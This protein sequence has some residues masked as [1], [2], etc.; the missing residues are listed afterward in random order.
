MQVKEFER[1]RRA[2]RARR[3]YELLSEAIA[4]LIIA[5]G[6]CQNGSAFLR[7]IELAEKK[8]GEAKECKV[9]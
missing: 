7:R 5:R 3:V 8:I 1:K 2:R 6:L 4:E 9:E